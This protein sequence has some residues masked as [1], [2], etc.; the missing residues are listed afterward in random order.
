MRPPPQNRSWIS[1]QKRKIKD[2]LP[3]LELKRK[4]SKYKNEATVFKGL[5]GAK[6]AF[7]DVLKSLKKGEEYHVLGFTDVSG[8]LLAFLKNFHRQRSKKGIKVKLL[9]SEQGKE[10]AETIKS[11]PSTEIKF[12]PSQLLSSSFVLM[13]N[14]KVLIT[15]AT[16]DNLTLFKIE[17]KE[18][19]DSFRSQFKLI[20]N[21][22]TIVNK[23][24]K[25]MSDALYNIINTVDPKKGYS[26]LNACWGTEPYRQKYIDFFKKYHKERMRLKVNA[27]LLF[28]PGIRYILED[29]KSNYE[30]YLQYK[31][32][33]Y[34]PESPVEVFTTEDKAILIIQE[35]EPI[36]ITINNKEVSK[37]FKTNFEALWSISK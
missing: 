30:K 11:I 2:I 12:A 34:K 33:P 35:K 18:V 7:D 21:Q 3:E 1:E 25:A 9:F 37:S 20:W 10:Y 24:F 27:K 36:V 14:D 6:T 13:Y 4:L 32:M 8:S 16:K 29:N 23:G 15:V 19:A 28:N 31:V 22:D 17:N 26:A 5:K